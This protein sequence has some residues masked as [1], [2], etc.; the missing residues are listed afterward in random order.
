MSDSTAPISTQQSMPSQQVP[1]IETSEPPRGLLRSAARA[2]YNSTAFLTSFLFHFA[3]LL[4]LAMFTFTEMNKDRQLLTVIEPDMTEDLETFEIELDDM[5]IVSTEMATASMPSAELGM[6]G[7]VEAS[8]ST[9]VLEQEAIEPTEHFKVEFDAVAMISK[10]TD[11]LIREIPSGTT[12]GSA[13][14]VVSDYQEAMDQITQELVWMLSKN[15]V[16][17]IWVFDQSESMVDD[18]KRIRER[19]GRV[20]TELGLTTEGQGDMLTTAVASYGQGFHL[21][22]DAPTSNLKDIQ[23]AID[24]IQVDKSGEE[25][26]CSA[27]MEAMS[28]H[29]KYAQTADRKVAL[30]LVTDESGNTA[31][32]QSQLEATI[33]AAKKMDCRLFILGREAMFGYPYA[34]Y[35]WRHPYDGEMH[36]LKIDRG[37]ETAYVEQLQTDGYG[38]R[39]DAMTSGFGPYEQ[40]RMAKE[41]GGRFFMLPGQE[42]KIHFVTDRQYEPRTMNLYRPD[43]RPREEQIAEIKGD[44]LKALVTKVVYDLNPFQED[45]KDVLTIRRWYSKEPQE[46]AKQIRQ[47]QSQVIPYGQYLDAAIATMEKNIKLRNDS[48]SLRWQANFDLIL[49]QLYAYRCRAYEYGVSSE[50]FLKNPVLPDPKRAEYLEFRGW[51]LRTRKQ[52]VAGDKT[53]PDAERAKELLAKVA[54][55][56]KGTP[57]ATRATWEI[58][59]G[60]GSAIV[61]HYF[62]V[63]NRKGDMK[64]PIPKL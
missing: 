26:S 17:A 63:R 44:P 20:Y 52:L 32:N 47:E 40:V 8:V 10:D 48:P 19:I 16:L 7:A 30:I 15:K 23:A 25:M 31:N 6:G 1:A 5:E 22:T 29:Y 12:L 60:F 36:L 55:D 64:V 33:A 46:T 11:S 13:Q 50:L 3:L 58:K 39:W 38:Q 45:R 42:D 53:A 43:L 27:I 34:H 2:A 35:E 18:Q 28:R 57:W 54:E 59:R 14:E 51:E 24:A 41:S 61:P 62:D 4:A 56:Y 9:P 49:G 21:L 37:P